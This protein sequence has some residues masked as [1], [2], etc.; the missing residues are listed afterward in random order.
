MNL[1]QVQNLIEEISAII[2]EGQFNSS[3]VIIET[4]HKI[5]EAI[6]AH[7]AYKKGK[8]GNG[9]LISY[10]AQAL[11]K[12]EQHLYLCIKFVDKF[13]EVSN[14]L[15]TLQP[16]K[17]SPTW[18]GVAA[19]LYESEVKGVEVK[20][21]SHEKTYTVSYQCCRACGGRVVDKSKVV[22]EMA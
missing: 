15:E 10:L 5:G 18:R 20:T 7:P 8:H 3:Q 19:V 12:S 2:S 4:N 13:P 6:V 21:C 16:E 17:K 1:P 9:E 14:A 11:N 22:K